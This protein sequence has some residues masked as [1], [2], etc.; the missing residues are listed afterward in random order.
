MRI[1]KYKII[2]IMICALCVLG[3][4]W[5][6]FLVTN[7]EELPA[8]TEAVTEIDALE[9]SIETETALESGEKAETAGREADQSEGRYEGMAADVGKAEIG[10]GYFAESENEMDNLLHSDVSL[11]SY[12]GQT[13][14]VSAGSY[15]SVYDGGFTNRYNVTGDGDAIHYAYCLQPDAPD[16]SGSAVVYEVDNFHIKLVICLGMYGPAQ[17]YGFDAGI[18]PGLDE[19]NAG[20]YLPAAFGYVHA[21]LGYLYGAG[22]G[23]GLYSEH[24]AQLDQW[25]QACV[26][27]YNSNP[28]VKKIVDHS[29]L[30]YMYGGYGQDVAWVEYEPQQNGWIEIY[31]YSANET[32]TNNNDLYSLAGAVYGVYD[33]QN[34]E[35]GRI[36][37]DK[38]GWGQLTDIPGGEYSVKEIEAPQG[39]FV[40]VTAHNV[41][42]KPG[43]MVT[44]EMKDIP[45]T[46]PVSVLLK[47]MDEDTNSNEPSGNLSLEGALFE[48]S[49]YNISLDTDPA[50]SGY[51]PERRW[52]LKTDKDGFC[53]LNDGYKTSG[54][55][56]YYD[57]NGNVVL[58]LGTVTI[59]E[60]QPPEGYLI[61][62]EI[63][64]RQVFP[65]IS[66]AVPTYNYPEISDTPQKIQI[67][68]NKVDSETLDNGAQGSGSLGGAEYEIIDSKNKVVG[69]LITDEA[70]YAVS[71]E[72]P[73]GIYKVKETASSKGYLVDKNIYTVDAKEP[74]DET[75][76]VF[77][78]KVTSGEDIIR[79]DLEIIK[80]RNNPDTASENLIPLAGVEFTL[81]SK[82]T[83][84]IAKVITTDDQ[85]RAS[86]VDGEAPRGSLVYDTYIITETKYPDNVKP[87]EPFEVTISEEGVILKGIYKEN[88]FIASPVAVVK[89]DGGTG[90]VIPMAGTEFRLLDEDKKPISMT[91]YYPSNKPVEIFVTDENG[92]F[93]FPNQLE[94]GTYYLE[95][96][97]APEG[98]LKGELLEFKVTEGSTWEKPL[99]I[100]YFNEPVMGKIQ[101]IKS[102]GETGDLLSQA[103]FEIAAA[104]DIVTPDGTIRLKKGE[105]ADTVI[106]KEGVGESKALFLGKYKVKEVRQPEGYIL[107][108]NTYDVTLGYKDQSTPVVFC[109][110]EIKN[111]PTKIQLFKVDSKTEQPLEKVE[112]KIWSKDQTNEQTYVTDEKGMIEMMYLLPGTYC[113]QETGGL[114]GYAPDDRIYEFTVAEDG[115]IDGKET[116]ELHITN[117]FIEIHTEASDEA[118][119]DQMITNRKAEKLVDRVNYKGL[120]PG[121]EYILRGNLM[122]KSTGKPLV[123]DGQEVVVEKSFIPETS[124]GEVEL[125]FT[126]DASAL[127][128]ERLV[129]FEKL[130]YEQ[131]ELAAH[132]EMDDENQTVEVVE[133][134]L[135]TSATNKADGK[136]KITAQGKVTVVDRVSYMNLIPGCQY[137]ISGILMDKKTGSELLLDGG[138][139]TT[140]A[141]F[142][143][144]EADGEILVEFTFDATELG[145]RDIVVFEKLFDFEGILLAA[146]EDI[147][148]SN[149]TVH[150]QKLPDTPKTGDTSALPKGAGLCLI[151]AAVLIFIGNH[152]R[153]K[154]K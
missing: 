76:R 35:V 126:V 16:P 59:Q 144:D 93:T 132:A 51:T 147:Q 61:N 107:D 9:T 43:E 141:I 102:D 70:G 36:V 117:T 79:G 89:K 32:V 58:P 78:Y 120:I 148:D 28:E 33:M 129:V 50:L 87:V 88:K 142:E 42:V 131:E 13:L 128:G 119:G 14:Y 8:E 37:T 27:V 82:T 77:K 1:A 101:I 96:I 71:G 40:D 64:V 134:R 7:A 90:N 108:L 100:E 127:V 63:F 151:S 97:N 49:F 2:H 150:F 85:G 109:E 123:Q 25:V 118:D 84:D 83:G 73:L 91:S 54:D 125:I 65:E 18:W 98:Y 66:G 26:D 55:D 56:F 112:F 81:T 53:K 86:T 52:T 137:K 122:V 149:Q 110:L 113:V 20:A 154:L 5:P 153:K 12:H 114:Y 69:V 94:C 4:L 105:V 68:L 30:F 143:P 124:D 19:Y 106:V 34:Q 6:L 41:T 139:V 146:H 47:K 111:T 99:I 44:V 10:E 75:S 104:E 48:L 145:G 15:T 31:K 11:F 72:L 57:S 133:I 116:G 21:T 60:K 80:F 24:V 38:N 74:I 46:A 17:Q 130:F 92:Q 23:A 3:I 140:E 115:R 67:E 138:E 29:K 136:K 95:E 62:D 135:G 121:K 22:P 39:F 103:E 152:K 45:Q